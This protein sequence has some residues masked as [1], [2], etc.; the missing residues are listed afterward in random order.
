MSQEIDQASNTQSNETTEY[1]VLPDDIT[2]NIEIPGEMY[3]ICHILQKLVEAEN[4][5]T[6]DN[7]II[8]FERFKSKNI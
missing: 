8:L 4:N 5:Y 7:F 3:A 6:I 1:E 2:N